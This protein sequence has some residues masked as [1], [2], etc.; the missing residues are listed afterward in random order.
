MNFTSKRSNVN[1]TSTTNRYL[2]PPRSK[3][4]RLSA[5]KSTVP[6]NCRVM[7]ARF[8]PRALAA[9]ATQGADRAL[10]MRVTHPEF[11]QRPTGDH[12]HGEFISCHHYGDSQSEANRAGCARWLPAGRSAKS[13]AVAVSAT[14]ARRGLQHHRSYAGATDGRRYHLGFDLANSA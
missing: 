9:L 11:P 7:S 12:L 1:D 6:P 10:G 14:G 2:L 3:M 8:A 5:T 4:T 13:R